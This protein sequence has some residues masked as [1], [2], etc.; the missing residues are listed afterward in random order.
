MVAILFINFF[1]SPIASN[2]IPFFI[3]SDVAGAP[4]YLFDNLLTPEL[5]SSVFSVLLGI[6]SLV[7]SV[8][9]SAKPQEE[10]CGRK[11]ALRI[12]ATAFIM[13]G[14]TVSYH[15]S[16]DRGSSLNTFLLLFCGGCLIIGFLIACV[17]IPINTAFMRIVERDKLSKVTSI[18]SII[19]QGLIPF[20]SILA[21]IVLQYLG[22]TPLLFVCTVGFTVSAL[23]LLFN[24]NVKDI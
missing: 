7:G 14:L 5:W 3:K 4:N 13:I 10:K 17:N 11:I 16:V 2:F 1:L 21:G 19:S 24:K 9:M 23:M 8:L 20:S 12:L 6:S 15:F 18:V 22:C